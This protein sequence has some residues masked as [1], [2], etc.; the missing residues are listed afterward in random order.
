MLENALLLDSNGKPIRHEGLTQS[1][2]WDE[3][4]EFCRATYMP[5]RVLR[6]RCGRRR[7][8]VELRP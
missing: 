6:K 3:V 8:L 7:K 4:Q 5:Y 2:D 1:T